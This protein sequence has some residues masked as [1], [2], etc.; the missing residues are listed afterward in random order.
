MAAITYDPNVATYAY[1]RAGAIAANTVLFDIDTGPAAVG[2]D[3]CL[4]YAL[5]GLGL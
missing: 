5:Q 2:I 4:C 3:F 1:T